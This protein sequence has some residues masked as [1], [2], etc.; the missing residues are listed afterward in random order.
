MSRDRSCIKTNIIK[1]IYGVFII[2][3]LIGSGRVIDYRAPYIKVWRYCY[4]T[5]EKQLERQVALCAWLTGITLVLFHTLLSL[6]GVMITEYILAVGMLL[7]S[8][9]R[10]VMI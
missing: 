6:G 7:C 5:L 2:Y 1:S 9:S 4:G 10:S 8:G 3:V